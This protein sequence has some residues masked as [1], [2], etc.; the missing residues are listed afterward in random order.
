MQNKI[1]VNSQLMLDEVRLELYQKI[2][3]VSK[4]LNEKSLYNYLLSFE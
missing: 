2:M 4:Y 3:T 1:I